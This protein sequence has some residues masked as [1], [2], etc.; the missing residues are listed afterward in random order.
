MECYPAT[1]VLT[2]LQREPIAPLWPELEPLLTEHWREID[3]YPD[4]PME[5]N[6]SMYE[7]AE[8]ADKL[9][10]YTLRTGAGELV[11]YAIYF[12]GLSPHY[13]A[14]KQ[15]THDVLYVR[16]DWRRGLIGLQLIQYADGQLRAEGVQVVYQ[17]VRTCLDFSRLLERIGYEQ[18]E[19]VWARRLDRCD[20]ED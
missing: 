3:P 14:S 4:I 6:R 13:R 16:P 8:T 1:E 2:T 20:E 18:I 17:K 7:W 11:G 19:T 12:V 10:V 9:R 5:A 15:A